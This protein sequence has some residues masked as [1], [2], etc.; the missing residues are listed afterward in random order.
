MALSATEVS[1]EP[2][3]DYLLQLYEETDTMEYSVLTEIVENELVQNAGKQSFISWFNF[4][5]IRGKV[6]RILTVCL[7]KT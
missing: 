5:N 7:S 2:V 3:K 4:L 1:F 6:Q